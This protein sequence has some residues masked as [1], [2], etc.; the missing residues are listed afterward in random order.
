VLRADGLTITTL[1]E[2]I[3]PLF[4]LDLNADPLVMMSAM[5]NDRLDPIV[6]ARYLKIVHQHI[7]DPIAV[8]R[9]ERFAF[10]QRAQKA[11]A[12]VKIRDPGRRVLGDPAGGEAIRLPRN[13]GSL[14]GPHSFF[15][16]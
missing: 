6:E 3:L 13:P 8:V 5:E 10:Y 1:L 4:E 12:V 9:M 14:I 7:Q 16:R 2:G 11:F 15:M